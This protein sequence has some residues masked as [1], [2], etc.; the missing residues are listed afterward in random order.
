MEA[1][2]ARA[3]WRCQCSVLRQAPQVLCSFEPGTEFGP[4]QLAQHTGRFGAGFA[5][6]IVE[7]QVHAPGI[8][9][10]GIREC[11]TSFYKKLTI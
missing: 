7:T 6:Q 5:A 2:R 11:K 1:A 8:D 9:R 4:V 10:I 3:A